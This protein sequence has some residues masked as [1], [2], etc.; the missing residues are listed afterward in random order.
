[1]NLQ[2]C[3]EHTPN[4]RNHASTRLDDKKPFQAVL[5]AS[6]GLCHRQASLEATPLLPCM[7]WTPTLAVWPSIKADF[8]IKASGQDRRYKAPERLG[9]ERQ[10][11]NPQ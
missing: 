9:R 7:Y 10:P 5:A 8:R 1:M 3:L 4:L 11:D 6:K 2:T